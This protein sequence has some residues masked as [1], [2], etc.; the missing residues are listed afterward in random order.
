MG[1]VH[2][3]DGLDQSKIFSLEGVGQTHPSIG[4]DFWN[5]LMSRSY[6]RMSTVK[7]RSTV[8]YIFPC[9]HSILF[10]TILERDMRLRL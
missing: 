8:I 9:L 6:G 7:W 2:D 1:G 3:A 4:M 10:T 5:R